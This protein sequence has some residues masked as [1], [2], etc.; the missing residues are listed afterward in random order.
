MKKLLVAATLGGLGWLG[1]ACG[2]A[3]AN[4][5]PPGSSG[6]LPD[7]FVTVT[8]TILNSV[9]GS[10]AEVNG[11]G[12]TVGTGTYTEWVVSGDALNPLGGLDFVIQVSAATGDVGRVTTTAYDSFLV[13][14]GDALT[15]VNLAPPGTLTSG[16]IAPTTM[17]RLTS[18]VIGFNFAATIPAG[19][20][21]EFLVAKTNGVS[22]Q[23]G[24][25]SIIDGGTANVLG[26]APSA[27][28]V[29]ASVWGGL[30]LFGLV[31]VPRLL[32][33]RQAA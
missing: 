13:D 7:P 1:A 32:R 14:G 4:S 12:A 5:L 19:S 11:S 21:S 23:T 33:R 28:P 8:G 24:S 29:P 6:V 16:L 27:V 17:D 25:I 2:V 3:R 10:Y 26:F 15:L 22:Y 9:T 30:G 18:P 20:S 31:G